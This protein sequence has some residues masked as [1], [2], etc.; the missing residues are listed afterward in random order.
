MKKKIL[1]LFAV[2][3]AAIG[4]VGIA[5]V[6]AETVTYN[7]D[8]SSAS[9]TTLTDNNMSITLSSK[10]V[11]FNSKS[12]VT[13]TS[14]ITNTTKEF[15][16]G[17]KMDSAFSIKFTAKGNWSG[18]ISIV[19]KEAKSQSLLINNKEVSV[20]TLAKDEFKSFD[21]SGDKGDVEIK[22]SGSQNYAVELTL[23]V[24][25][26]NAT[27]YNVNYYDED[28]TT[29]FE[30]KEVESGTTASS[31]L[32]IKYTKVGYTFNKWLDSEGNEFDFTKTITAETN[33][34]ASYIKDE[35][36]TIENKNIITKSVISTLVNE[37]VTFN[38]ET[39]LTDTI[40]SFNNA[41]VTDDYLQI[42]RFSD[43]SYMKIE[44]TTPG[45]L[46]IVVKA[47]SSS[48]AKVSLYDSAKIQI[49][50]SEK[51]LSGN[52]SGAQN[53]TFAVSEAGTYYL[54]LS[55]NITKMYVY[56][57]EFING[58][59]YVQTGS[60][61]KNNETTY[62]VRFIAVVSVTDTSILEGITLDLTFN[63]VTKTVD[64]I[65]VDEITKDNAAYASDLNHSSYTFDV[66]NTYKYVVYTMAYQD[67]THNTYTGT[68]TAKLMF[69]GVEF[70]NNYINL[71]TN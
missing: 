48:A 24:E 20:G 18:K 35:N 9:G 31:E 3:L 12:K 34:Y 70:S 6:S 60:Q 41:S 32:D 68:L 57:A 52:E 58:N 51:T 56:S 19:G 45:V 66:K 10:A 54:G 42:N 26:S 17:I 1:A 59:L 5:K 27:Y 33:L 29:K 43:S 4:L 50:S 8:L 67:S 36:Y 61:T 69:N 40:Y 46:Y 14:I 25:E 44:V 63:D 28:K 39:S 22:K 13:G 15:T 64:G 55:D 37:N 62:F 11:Q 53:L 2:I 38:S 7:Y 30:T 71:T 21:I 65:I 23:T 16:N 47:G 49:T